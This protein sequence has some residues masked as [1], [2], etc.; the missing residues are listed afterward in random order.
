MKIIGFVNKLKPFLTEE[1]FDVLMSSKL[2][3]ALDLSQED[4]KTLERYGT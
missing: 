4:P 3:D 1:S 2:L